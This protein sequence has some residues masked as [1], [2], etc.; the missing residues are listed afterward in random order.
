MNRIT[1]AKRRDPEARRNA[2]LRAAQGLIAGKGVNAMTIDDIVHQAGVAK[3][4]FYLYFRN[5]N[6]VINAVVEL[7]FEHLVQGFIAEAEAQDSPIAERLLWLA[8][9]LVELARQPGALELSLTVH[10]SGNIAVHR[11]LEEKAASLLIPIVEKIIAEG[12]KSGVFTVDNP[13]LCARWVAGAFMG[14]DYAFNDSAE[15]NAAIAHLC[16]FILRG[17]GYQSEK[18]E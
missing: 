10:K 18:N 6:D 12:I 7:I 2:I 11:R 5:K 13:Y 3:G 1:A 16:G 14:L 8:K 4:T 9:A 15:I 17:L